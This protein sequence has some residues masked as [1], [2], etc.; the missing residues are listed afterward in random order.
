MNKSCQEDV[1]F[2]SSYC[3]ARQKSLGLADSLTGHVNAGVAMSVC[4]WRWILRRW[5]HV[6]LG[7]AFCL[8]LAH[9]QTTAN[10]RGLVF[11][12]ATGWVPAAETLA[13]LAHVDRLMF[14]ELR[15]GSDGQ[16]GNPYG[17]PAQWGELRSAATSR[18]I[19]LDLV[20]TQFKVAH[21]NALFGS[22]RRVRQLESE[23]LRLAADSV[24]SGIH[25]DV[26]IIEAADAAAVR[27]YRDFV[28]SLGRQ[29]KAMQPL[30]LLS[31]FF[32]H[33]ADK[34]L[35][36]AATLALVDH[37]IVQGYDSHWLEA[38]VAGPVAPLAGADAVNWVQMLGTVQS[39]GV[40]PQRV[41][42]G[43]P[44]YGYEWR[45]TPC[46]PR[47]TRVAP[48]STTVFGR[49]QLPQAPAVK[50]SVMERVLM[51]GAHYDSDTGSAYYQFTHADGSCVVGWFEDWWTLQR[52]LDWLQ[53][54]QL[55]GLAMFPLGYDNGELVSLA[56][57]RL[58]QVRLPETI[59]FD[60]Q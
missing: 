2:G 9:A 45:V 15:M 23:V 56:A 12:Y 22:A 26:E 40:P 49:V 5:L 41:L 7:A 13:S 52:K 43:F 51:H 54:H 46:T 47:G 34:R 17:W 37:V 59:K 44:T 20:L 4:R 30:R 25:L 57:R 48:G 39:L 60:A 6:L 58:R 36:D 1:Q 53:A 28:V 42:M 11:G 19:P 18:G 29:L 14:M 31:V 21:F 10:A 32:Y 35:Y 38:G 55:A 24:V 16:I 3:N 8:P 50:A 33:G 27:R